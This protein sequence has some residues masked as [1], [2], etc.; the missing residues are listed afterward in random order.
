MLNNNK[1][2]NHNVDTPSVGCPPAGGVAEPSYTLPA[3]CPL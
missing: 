1:L 3:G 2:Y